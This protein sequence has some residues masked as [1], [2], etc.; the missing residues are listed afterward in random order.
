MVTLGSVVIVIGLFYA[1]I[2]S[3]LES[4]VTTLRD[5]VQRNQQ[6]LSFMQTTDKQLQPFSDK[7]FKGNKESS[8]SLLSAIQNQLKKPP[9]NKY[10][11]E[12]KQA[13]AGS[14]ELAFK[15][16]NF[17]ILVTWLTRMSEQKRWVITQMTIARSATTGMVS[18]TFI[19]TSA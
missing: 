2:W 10:S 11:A 3:P 18:A 13:D 1:L 16:V 7:P 15:Q 17:D 12:L 14:V 19:L 4:K 5:K 8:S 6:L 9:L